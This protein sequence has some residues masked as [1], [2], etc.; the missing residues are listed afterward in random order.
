MI[1]RDEAQVRF[2]RGHYAAN[3]FSGLSLLKVRPSRGR[4]C[5]ITGLKFQ[6]PPYKQHVLYNMPLHYARPLF[7]Y[8][9]HT[10]VTEYVLC[11]A[12]PLSKNL[13]CF[14]RGQLDHSCRVHSKIMPISPCTLAY[15][16]NIQHQLTFKGVYTSTASGQTIGQPEATEKGNSVGECNLAS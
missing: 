8:P 9:L 3:G 6:G 7:S 14:P 15:L 16:T 4:Y 11:D 10:R 2:P 12:T 13:V 5:R 1:C